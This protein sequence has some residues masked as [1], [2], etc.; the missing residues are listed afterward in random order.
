MAADILATFVTQSIRL[1]SAAARYTSWIN[2][3][4]MLKH[5]CA[6][7]TAASLVKLG[8]YLREQP[9]VLVSLLGQETCWNET[10]IS[11]TVREMSS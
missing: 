2:I 7:C 11:E 3:I 5:L 8:I 6:L 1:F 10:W 4:M 9:L